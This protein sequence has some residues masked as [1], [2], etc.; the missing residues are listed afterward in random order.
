MRIALVGTG[1]MG[2]TVERLAG[3]RGHDVVARFDVDRPL[4][5]ANPDALSGADV[6]IEFSLP[7]AVPGNVR[8]YCEAGVP[9]VIGTTGWYDALDDVR[10]MVASSDTALLYAPNFSLGIALVVRALRGVM[11]LLNRLPE[12]DVFVHEVHHVRK[13][14]SPSG[15]ALLLGRTLLDGLD[16]KQRIETETQHG[17]IDPEALHVTSSR[18]GTVFGEHSVGID[19][20]FDRIAIS[21]EARGREGFAF[22]ALRSAEW[23]IGKK[24]MFTLDDVLADW[25]G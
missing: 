16:R 6:A 8:R 21:H 19:S 15:T 2:S 17:R 18:A 25:V 13:V 11:P 5:E 7:D 20:A 23:L 10:E 9:A 4:S 3:E 14:D 24:G 12:Y 1:Q 22:G